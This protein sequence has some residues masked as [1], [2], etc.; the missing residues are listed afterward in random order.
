MSEDIQ[1]I[2]NI[3]GIHSRPTVPFQRYKDNLWFND[4][5]SGQE[6]LVKTRGLKPTVLQHFNVGMTEN[7]E[8]VIPVFKD[9]ELIDYKFRK[10]AEKEFHRHPGAETWVVNEQAFQSS[11]EDG[12]IICVEGEFDAMA[13]YQLGFRSVI[14]TT[15][16]AQA[17]TPWVK[18][19]PDKIK[20]YI[21]Y[22]ND[23][24]GQDA[25]QK[26]AERIGIN[27][28]FNI[29]FP[30]VKDAND[31]LLKGAKKSDFQKLI[32]KA[33]KFRIKDVFQVHEIIDKLRD[34]RLQRTPV[35]SQRL[36]A[37][38]NGGI[39]A[40]SLVTISGRTGV[41]KSTVLMNMLV[42]HANEGRPVLLVSLENDL[43]FTVQRVLEVK[44]K[45]PYTTFTEEDWIRVR[46]DMA[47][48]PLYIDV[49]MDSYTMPKIE[50]IIEQAKSLYGIEFFG[51]DHIGF[52]PTRD[53][54]KEISQM[55]RNFKLLARQYD[56]IVYMISHVRRAQGAS[57]YVTSEEL[58]GSSSIAQ[59]SDVVLIINDS[60]AGLEISIDKARMSKSH[61]RIPILFDG[62]SGVMSD[63]MSRSVKQYDEEISD[64]VATAEKPV[65]TPII[66]DEEKTEYNGELDTY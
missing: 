9:G 2:K 37:H 14:S 46:N 48:Y 52:L 5:K 36:T 63:D 58:K 21:C 6:F 66:N 7:K 18:K 23:E 4:D 32:S 17:P 24:P 50:K 43:Y 34:N 44:Y 60:K 31:F 65:E 10:I 57:D 12:Y 22:D 30:D 3:W 61:L 25:A 49:S 28:C 47:D 13:L 40:K 41:G 19:I 42:H 20:V 33:E 53:D 55:V 64:P 38:L 26:L 35:F 27:R 16:G 51:F 15:G 59:D 11:A 29:K 8:V 62:P 39:S 54:P 45:K 56:I 1:S